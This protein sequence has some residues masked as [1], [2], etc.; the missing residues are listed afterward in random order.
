[1]NQNEEGVS[2]RDL[3]MSNQSAASMI[4]LSKLDSEVQK[5]IFDS[6]SNQE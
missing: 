3:R 4:E 6:P 5:F 2:N 1:M